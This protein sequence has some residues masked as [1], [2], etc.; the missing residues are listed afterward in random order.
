MTIKELIP[1]LEG[2]N[3]VREL[4][5]DEVKAA[6]RGETSV[7]ER[8]LI[9]IDLRQIAKD[10]KF[11]KDFDSA[12]SAFKKTVDREE[13][14]LLEQE[15]QDRREAW[16]AENKIDL[17]DNPY[18]HLQSRMYIINPDGVFLG[19]ERICTR[20]VLVFGKMKNME[21]DEEAICIAYLSH[22]KWL[23]QVVKREVLFSA[24]QVIKLS[25]YGLNV[26]SANAREFI[27]FLDVFMEE[28]QAALE[29]NLSVSRLGWLPDGRFSPYDEDV[30]RCLVSSGN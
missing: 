23:K 13:K 24:S 28:N 20:P 3:S 25:A 7:E 27:K 9:R 26:H 8:E 15:K 16:A 30:V 2:A 18:P 11:L 19:S 17:Y 14:A 5:V 12:F 22:G 1:T 21:T 4:L 6:Y 29:P 10:R